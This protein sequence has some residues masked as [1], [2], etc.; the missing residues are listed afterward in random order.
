MK[1]LKYFVLSLFAF[2]T[3]SCADDKTVTPIVS[4]EREAFLA[5]NAV[6]L[7]QDGELRFRCDKKDYQFIVDLMKLTS[8]AQH[9]DGEKYFEVT[10]S[11]MP[12]NSNPISVTIAENVGLGAIHIKTLTPLRMNDDHLWLWSDEDHMG[13]IL[14]WVNR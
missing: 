6:G 13:L 5:T 1:Y 8:R 10:L 2:T 12:L 4:L 3:L 14:A 11:A 7:Y 9:D